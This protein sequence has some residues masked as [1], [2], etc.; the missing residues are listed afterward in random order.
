MIKEDGTG[1]SWNRRLEVGIFVNHVRRF[2]TEFKRD[3]FQIPGRR[4]HNKPAYL[5]RP[6]KCY[7]VYV[8]VRSESS[9]CSLAV[10]GDNIDH[11]FRESSFHDQFAQLERGQ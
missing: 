9:A 7:L 6:C 11:A 4:L 10:S 1:R 2:A 5:G 8:I 3:F